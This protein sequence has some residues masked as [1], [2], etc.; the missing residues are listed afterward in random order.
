MTRCSSQL[1]VGVKRRRRWAHG[2]TRRVWLHL[3]LRPGAAAT[4]GRDRR[5][6]AGYR[7][8]VGSPCG[9]VAEEN[10][11]F[12]RLVVVL[13]APRARYWVGAIAK[14]PPHVGGQ[15]A[16]G[17]EQAAEGAAADA[18][19]GVLL[20]HVQEESFARVLLLSSLCVDWA[21]RAPEELVRGN[22]GRVS[23]AE[24]LRCVVGKGNLADEA[25]RPGPLSRRRCNKARGVDLAV[26]L[27]HVTA[28]RGGAV[29]DAWLEA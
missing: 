11:G 25:G 26:S 6:V 9:V 14:V 17:G 24:M 29:D 21:L 7:G 1:S 5:S 8:N 19:V 4:R 12:P 16:L 15:P 20:G 23:L 3:P 2:A 28:E 13:G 10:V 22:R 18:W 27:L